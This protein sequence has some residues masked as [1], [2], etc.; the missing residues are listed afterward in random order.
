MRN[1][2]KIFSRGGHLPGTLIKYDFFRLDSPYSFTCLKALSPL[3]LHP[4]KT[5]ILI[6][7]TLMLG[8]SAYAQIDQYDYI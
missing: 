3:I 2:I 5:T 7:I 6:I 8:L 4:M 1:L